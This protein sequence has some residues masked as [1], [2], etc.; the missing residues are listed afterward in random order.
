MVGNR[1]LGEE[2]REDESLFVSLSVA[3]SSLQVRWRTHHRGLGNMEKIWSN[4][5][6]N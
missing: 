5:N 4:H 3:G 6:R 1:D 2:R